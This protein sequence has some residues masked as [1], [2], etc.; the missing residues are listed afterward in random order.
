MYAATN[1]TVAV[2]GRTLIR[3]VDMAIAPGRLVAVIGPNGAGK[4]TLLRALA[5]ERQPASGSVSLH[6]RNVFALA[7]GELARWRAV[8]AQTVT[9][10]F[11]FSVSEIARLGARATTDAA[12]LD[13]LVTR[14][15]AAVHMADAAERPI[16]QLSGGEQQRVHLARVL[17]QLWAQPDDGDARYLLLDEPTA[18]LDPAHQVLAATLARAHAMA[19]GGV[20]AVLHDVNLAAGI[21]DEIIVMQS[22]SLV[23]HGRPSEILDEHLL[24]DVF[25]IPFLAIGENGRRVL[26]PALPGHSG[27]GA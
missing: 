4:S 9:V 19:G 18:H 1:L 7:A 17:V 22:G 3:N 15:L 13:A 26:M 6:G 12:T 5:G 16:T 23:A 21:A 25:G 24:A 11:P 2:G 20:L 8:L 14:A 27:K 10:T